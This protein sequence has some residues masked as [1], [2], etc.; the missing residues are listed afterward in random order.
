MQIRL[1]GV[2]N[3]LK[4]C[5]LLHIGVCPRNGIVVVDVVFVVVVAVVVLAVAC[6]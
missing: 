3:S 2:C 1:Y 5:S 4:Y 6:M